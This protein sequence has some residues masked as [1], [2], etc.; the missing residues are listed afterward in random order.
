MTA[1]QHLSNSERLIWWLMTG[2]VG[3][4]CMLAWAHASEQSAIVSA[5]QKSIAA[6]TASIR[7]IEATQMQILETLREIRADV[8]ALREQKRP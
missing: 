2:A 5:N 3:A 1:K 4:S 6:N 8:R 7:A